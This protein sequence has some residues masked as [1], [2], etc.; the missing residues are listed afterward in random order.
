MATFIKE[1]WE[2]YK[3]ICG[4]SRGNHIYIYIY[5]AHPGADLCSEIAYIYTA[6]TPAQTSVRIVR[7]AY[8]Y[9]RRIPLAQTPI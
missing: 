6:H 2:T 1:V 4:A 8:I 9:I 3:N 7:I 5:G